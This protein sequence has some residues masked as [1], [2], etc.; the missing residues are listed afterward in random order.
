[1]ANAMYDTGRDGYLG[2]DDDWDSDHRL[3]FTTPST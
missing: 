3:I 2:G 1:M